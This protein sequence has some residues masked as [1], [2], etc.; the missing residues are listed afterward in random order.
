M[1]EKTKNN[2]KLEEILTFPPVKIKL[3]KAEKQLEAF[4]H[5]SLPKRKME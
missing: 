2:S 5:I 3:Y 4:C 1:L